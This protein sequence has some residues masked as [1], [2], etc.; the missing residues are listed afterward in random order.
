MAIADNIARVEEQIQNAC[1][2]AGRKRE[3]ITLVAV[4]KT[5]EPEQ[6]RQAMDC[7][8]TRLAENRVQE[9]TRKYDQ[10][11]GADWHLIGHLQS[12]KVK[13]IVDKVS[14]IHAVES[15]SLAREIDRQSEKHGKISDIL[16]EVNVS[17]E[18]SKFGLS[19][20]AVQETLS[21]MAEFP[22]IRVRGLMT[23]APLLANEKEIRHIFSTLY[24]IS[25]D[26]ARNPYDNVSMEYLSMG[27]SNDFP[28]AIAE[29][30]THIRVG[31]ALF[32]S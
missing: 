16:L 18:E 23:M 31:R 9:L 25:V 12:N 2:R 21:Q 8:L 20:A 27:M 22:H 13:Y 15:V 5:V 19:P 11:P 29:G 17:G 30:A 1:A 28:L 32:Q 14:L 6:I 4:T 24:K 7:G 10:L 3:E 26:N